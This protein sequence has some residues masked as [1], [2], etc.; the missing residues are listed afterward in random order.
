MS[1]ALEHAAEP[2]ID[3][4]RHLA[5]RALEIGFGR[6][7][8]PPAT[9]GRLRLIVRRTPGPRETP[10]AAVLTPEEGLEG[11]AW[12]RRAPGDPNAQLTVMRH[13][14]AELIANGQPLT[15]FGDNLFVDLDISAG[16]LPA[17]TRL[18]LGE[19]IV[20][21]TPEP[22]MGCR[23]FRDRFGQDALRFTADRE[24]RVHNAR[25]IHWRVVEAGTIRVGDRIEVLASG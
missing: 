23:K 1:Q 7:A 14:I 18:R 5:L 25:G 21:V 8:R 15:L 22:H 24:I 10:A 12:S 3:A 11:D 19:C 20:E 16:N 17:G 6:L 9:A 13:D 2:R 4:A